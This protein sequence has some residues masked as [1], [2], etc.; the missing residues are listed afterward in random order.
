M[1]GPDVLEELVSRTKTREG[2]RS[3][4]TLTRI[5]FACSIVFGSLSKGNV[6]LILGS[7]IVLDLLTY[8]TGWWWVGLCLKWRVVRER[9][10]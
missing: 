6:C 5:F 3:D 10:L 4:I 2:K 9:M 8:S 7:G 1:N